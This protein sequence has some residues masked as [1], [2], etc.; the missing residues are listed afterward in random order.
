MTVVNGTNDKGQ[1]VG[2]FLD[3]N[4]NTVGFVGTPTPEPSSF[5]MAGLGALAL[6]LLK[7]R[8]R[9]EI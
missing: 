1:I 4:E 8:S 5:M 9:R 6:G 7:R 2:F 3:A